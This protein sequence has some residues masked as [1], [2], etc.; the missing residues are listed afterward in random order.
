MEVI[1]TT[2]RTNTVISA[3]SLALRLSLIFL[4]LVV[5]S[6][7]TYPQKFR[8]ARLIVFGACQGL[9]NQAAFG[10]RHG[11]SRPQ[12]QAVVGTRHHRPAEIEA[13][14]LFSQDFTGAGHHGAFQGVAELAHVSGP[15]VP[16][17]GFERLRGNGFHRAAVFAVQA[18]EE[19]RRQIR[20]VVHM[21]AQGGHGDVHNIEAEIQ[22]AAELAPGR[23]PPPGPY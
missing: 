19:R 1:T 3:V 10:I 14:V 6:F 11:H 5:Q 17:Q 2:S 8:G 9:V 20:K 23:R 16:A 22:I 15:R 13:Q 7:Q 12:A 4:Q 18:I 21:L